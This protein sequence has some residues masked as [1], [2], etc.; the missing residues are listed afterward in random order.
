MK[1]VAEEEF[2][3]IYKVSEHEVG[4][5]QPGSLVLWFPILFVMLGHLWNNDSFL[6]EFFTDWLVRKLYLEARVVDIL[7][8]PHNA[9][10]PGP[11]QP[12]EITDCFRK[13]LT[14]SAMP[15]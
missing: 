12:P 11:G 6:I 10:P 2:I 9:A 14:D 13:S 7:P 15:L 8:P 5:L 3:Y 1:R 4:G